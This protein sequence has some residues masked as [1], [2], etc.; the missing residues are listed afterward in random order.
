MTLYEYGQSK[1][2]MESGGGA[3]IPVSAEHARS[4]VGPKRGRLGEG[5]MPRSHRDAIGMEHRVA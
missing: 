5:C 3:L 1:E 2:V 4:Q